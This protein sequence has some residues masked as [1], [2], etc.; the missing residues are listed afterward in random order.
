V[1]SVVALLVLVAPLV[2]VLRGS[3]A[4][5]TSISSSSMLPTLAKGDVV[6][7]DRGVKAADLERG[8]LITFTGPVD[9]RPNLKRII[10]LPGESVVIKDAVLHVDGRPVAEPYVDHAAIDAYFSRTFD[11]P[12][13][14]V[15]VMGDNRGNSEDSRDYGPVDTDDVTGRVLVRFWPPLRTGGPQPTP[16]KP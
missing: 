1:S 5:P 13:G 16:P 9:G 8:D 15:F 2:A 11:V 4:A 14:T 6:L 12:T 10:G 3:I 7:V